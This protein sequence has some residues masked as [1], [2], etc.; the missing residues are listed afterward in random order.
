MISKCQTPAMLIQGPRGRFFIIMQK[1]AF[2]YF[3]NVWILKWFFA[4]ISW[5]NCAIVVD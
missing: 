5:S 3:K 2:W 1:S 4:K